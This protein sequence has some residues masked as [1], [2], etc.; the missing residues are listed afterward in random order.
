MVIM[1]VRF[2]KRLNIKSLS[3]CVISSV[4]FLFARIHSLPV[5]IYS[6]KIDIGD[7]LQWCLDIKHAFLKISKFVVS[8][9]PICRVPWVDAPRHPEIKKGIEYNDFGAVYFHIISPITLSKLNVL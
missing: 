3:T 9:L 4:D 6:I 7:F 5:L 1:I 2:P 8:S